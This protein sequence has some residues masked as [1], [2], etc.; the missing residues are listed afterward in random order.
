MPK[1]NATNQR[2]WLV[3][4]VEKSLQGLPKWTAGRTYLV[5]RDSKTGSIV[6]RHEIEPSRAG[7]APKK[8]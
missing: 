2:D 3:E 1:K 5:T 8:K 4:R 6:S 7:T